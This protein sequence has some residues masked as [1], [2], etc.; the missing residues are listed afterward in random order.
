MAKRI[1]TSQRCTDR[2][3][4]GPAGPPMRASLCED[5]R[6]MQVDEAIRTLR[7]S[8]DFAPTP[9]GDGLIRAWVDTARWCGSSENSQPW[10]FVVVR[11]REVLHAL[12]TFGDSAGHLE[13]C[14]VAIVLVATPGPYPFSLAFDLGRVAQCLMLV[15][16]HDGIGSCV[17][18]FGP[19]SNVVEAGAVVGVPPELSAGLAIG[20]GY[21]VRKQ[22]EAAS[23]PHG[24][25][26]T[27]RLDTA[28]LLHW[29]RFCEGA[30]GAVR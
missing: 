5:C 7:A 30:A 22:R 3:H 29:E 25:S 10:R 4:V 16:H 14:D 1:W 23:T 21:A 20:F 6:L 24:P 18:V 15:A 19:R 12:S 9:I 11:N 28:G 2:S 8:R 17:A 27:G 26:P 13:L